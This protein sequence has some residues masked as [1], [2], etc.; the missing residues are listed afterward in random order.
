MAMVGVL[1]MLRHELP[2]EEGGTIRARPPAGAPTIAVV[3]YPYGSNLDELRLV[4]HAARMRW[5]TD[6][7]DIEGADLVVL[8][9]S[10]HVAADAQWLRDRQLDDRLRAHAASGGRVLGL[11]G[12][13]MLLGTDISDPTGVEGAATGLGMLPVRTEMAPAKLTRRVNIEFP[14]L[15]APWAPLTGL[16]ATG[17]EIRNGFVHD[18]GCEVAPLLWA[19]G[20]VLATT[21]HGLLED[22]E[23][24]HALC[25][26]KVQDQLEDTFDLLAD[27]VDV[28]LDTALLERLT[29]GS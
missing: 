24:L 18:G 29:L 16:R 13:A 27:A 8:P 9:G 3:R 12:G 28:H 25:G 6:P 11:C 26:V 10:K 14:A 17:Y 15:T 19:R 20:P 7:E 22:A 1:P 5:A 23:V 21:V 4:P 2:D